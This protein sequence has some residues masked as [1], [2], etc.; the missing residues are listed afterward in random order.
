[1]AEIE[2][3]LVAGADGLASALEIDGPLLLV[4]GG[5]CDGRGSVRGCSEEIALLSGTCPEL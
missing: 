3:L 2:V 4:A 1:M 5:K